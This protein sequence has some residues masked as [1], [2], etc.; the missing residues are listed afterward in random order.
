MAAKQTVANVRRWRRVRYKARM[1]A[2]A[3]IL[4]ADYADRPAIAVRGEI[5]PFLRMTV[6]QAFDVTTAFMDDNDDEFDAWLWQH[7]RSEI[8][9]CLPQIVYQARPKGNV[10]NSVV[11]AADEQK[12]PACLSENPSPLLSTK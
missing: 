1:W 5:N 3:R 4:F 6:D 7:F 11:S 10:S 8:Q 2:H 9:Q 12:N